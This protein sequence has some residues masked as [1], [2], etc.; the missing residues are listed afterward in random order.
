MK[1][2]VSNHSRALKYRA[3][4]IYFPLC[5]VMLGC[6]YNEYLAF[7]NEN[8]KI[9]LVHLKSESNNKHLREL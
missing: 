3:T 4:S 9:I 5:M 1:N 2:N 7:E 6:L 8:L